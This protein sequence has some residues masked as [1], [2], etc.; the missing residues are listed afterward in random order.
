[1]NIAFITN[2][3]SHYRVK[4]FELLARYHNVTYLF[5][6]KGH[7]WYWQQ[8]HG[9]RTGAF[10]YEYLAGVSLGRT[11]I[12]PSLIWKTI[13]GRYDVVLKCINGR[14]AL[15][16]A[17]VSAR[18]S[19]RPF[20]LWTGIW[21]T[22]ATPFHRVASVFT[23]YIYGHA[24]A[25]VV[26][27]EHVKRFLISLGVA[28]ERIFV[29]PHAV[30]NAVY[31]RPVPA[32][33]V[34]QL[35]CALKIPRGADV[36]L[37]LGRL[38]PSKGLGYLLEAFSELRHSGT[39]LVI[40]GTGSEKARLSALAQKLN[41]ATM[42]RFSG[43]VANQATPAYYAMARMFVLP[44]ITMSTGKEPWGLVINEAFNQ[45]VPAITTDA[46]GAAAGGLVQDGI[47]GLI[48]PERDS[49]AL[50]EAMQRVL[51]SPALHDRMSWAAREMISTW[52]NEHMVK[53]FRDAIDFAYNSRLRS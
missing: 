28:P 48:V 24:D 50:A 40:A 6:S 34:A 25:I 31:A 37:Y 38:E 4:T 45:G 26:Y 27:G 20:V 53:G 9:V 44:S 11:R 22:L 3:A 30:D 29:A 16:A 7:E 32:S 2:F 42:V 17:Y 23:N 10:R 13:F 46:V 51:A 43:Y 47:N 14:F 12:T 49:H 5:F 18:I 39:Y 1:M 15:P 41:I 35:R 52:D 8:Q 21:S 33:E 36:I 19:R